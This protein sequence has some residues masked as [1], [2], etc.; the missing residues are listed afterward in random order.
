MSLMEERK[1]KGITDAEG[2]NASPVTDVV[3]K[4]ETGR[5]TL[6]SLMGI[7]EKGTKRELIPL[8][9]YDKQAINNY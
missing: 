3:S 7:E 9:E 8:D 2:K 5:Q 4:Y 6:Q 1:A